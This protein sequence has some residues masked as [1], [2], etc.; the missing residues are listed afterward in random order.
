MMNPKEYKYTRDHEWIYLGQENEGKVGITDY[1]QSH[2]GDIVFLYLP[3]PGTRIEQFGKLGEVEAVKA[4]S[5]IYAP[6]SGVVLTVNQA[7][8][9][10]PKL[11]NN[12]PYQEGWLLILELDNLNELNALMNSD[13]YDKLISQGD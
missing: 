9:D 3:D 11:V 2:L 5:E 8:I 12:S 10:D 1:A 7:A 4:V 6:A 13:E